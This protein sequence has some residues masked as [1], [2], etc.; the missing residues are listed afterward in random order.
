MAASTK[1]NARALA[2]MAARRTAAPAAA[3]RMAAARR[4][5]RARYD[6]AQTTDDNRRH[7]AAADNLSADA[8]ASP[9]VRRTLRN[10]A[11]YEVANNTYARGMVL[12][13]ANDLVGTRPRLQMQTDDADLN[14]LV[15]REF[16]AWAAA[17]GLAAKLRTMKAA[18][19]QDGEAFALLHTNERLPA[20]V[21]LDLRLIEADQVATP[22]RP[23]VPQPGAVDGIRYDGDGNPTEYHV[24]RRHPGEMAGWTPQDGFDR[25]P[26]G[27]VIHWYRTDRPGQRRG[28]PDIMPAL[29]LYALLRRFT[30]ATLHAAE[31]AAELAIVMKTIAGAEI[32]AAEVEPWITMEFER[33]MGV[34]APEG[35]EPSQLRAEHPSTTYGDFKREIISEIARCLNL[36]Y[37]VAAGDSSRHS[38]ASGRLDHQTYFK[39]LR[40][41]RHDLELVAL[42]PFFQAWL[43]EALW[44]REYRVFGEMARDDW[45]H[46]W[47]WDGREHVDPAKEARAQAIKLATGGTTLAIEYARQGL[48][49]EEQIKQRG[50][51]LA[52]MREKGVETPAA[53]GAEAVLAVSMADEPEAAP[54]AAASN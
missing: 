23:L 9:S 30:L 4:I 29:P 6:A 34:F 11:R 7:W 15:E 48:D 31:T 22:N 26:A 51:E 54:A 45:R 8:A 36:P 49:W 47:F 37:A 1:A 35:W 52:L 53:V 21:K 43:R 32:D 19:T 17:A 24:L 40:V 25:L 33:N 50:R 3:A 13:L 18:R 12:T 46:A 2:R 5:V 20:P 16:A 41:E 38:Y 42:E 44:V 14:A 39:S 28:L 27:S 10:R